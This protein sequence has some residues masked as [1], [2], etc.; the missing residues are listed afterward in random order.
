MGAG[1]VALAMVVVGLAVGRLYGGIEDK[2][3]AE[4]RVGLTVLGGF[5]AAGLI[6][7]VD[8]A[9]KALGLAHSVIAT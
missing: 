9:A 4:A 7:L 5:A 2:D 6:L 8:E 1:I 3:I